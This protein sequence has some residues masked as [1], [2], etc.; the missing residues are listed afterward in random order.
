M[1]KII[2]SIICVVLIMISIIGC[3]F[4]KITKNYSL[5][6][7]DVKVTQANSSFAFD[8]FKKLNEADT[9]NVF[10]SPLSIST[11]LTMTFQGAGSTTKEEMS[12]AL[13]YAGLDTATINKSYKNLLPYLNNIDKKIE[14]NINNS[15]WIREGKEIKKEFLNTNQEVFNAHISE[16][17]FSDEGA[18][19][20][21][22]NWISEATK[23]KI[24]KMIAS[25]ISPSVVMY[26][27]NAIYFKGQWSVEF[28]KNNSFESKFYEKWDTNKEGAPEKV[29]MM[30]RKGKVEYMEGAGF[31]AVRLPYGDGKISMYCIL[32]G[33]D[34]SINEFIDHMDLKKWNQIREEIAEES[35]VILQIPRFKINYGVK[36]LNDVL[37]DLGMNKAFQPGADFSGI[38]NDIFISRVLHK[39]VIEVN[40]EGSEAAGA[41]VVVMKEA[42][43]E[44]PITFIANRPFLFIIADDTTGTIL[45]M[46]KLSE[47]N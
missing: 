46:G 39:A 38:S 29:V 19:K 26:L 47:I 2:C 30:N 10:I 36:Q 23:G 17:D 32:P 43:V 16:L 20:T 35:E 18:A 33:E 4:E 1:K 31:K 8:I 40:E 7:I 21:I 44:K 3:G 34:V 24:N 45:F 25:P 15:I 5:D 37:K 6:K 28:D 14:L 11:A 27:I 13:K 42:A 41:T 12:R 22:N 9:G